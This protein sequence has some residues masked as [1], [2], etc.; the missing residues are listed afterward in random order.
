M[1][2][3]GFEKKW[4]LISEQPYYLGNVPIVQEIKIDAE[5]LVIKEFYNFVR[6]KK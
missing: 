3:T 2:A 5:D 1:A 6:C 4:D